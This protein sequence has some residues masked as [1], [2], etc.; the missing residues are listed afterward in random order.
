M[1]GAQCTH[2]LAC[3]MNKAHERSHHR[4]TG[5]FPAFPAQW[6][7]GLFR[8]LPGEIGLVCHRYLAPF[9]RRLDTGV[10]ASEPHDFAVRVSTIRHVRCSRPPHPAPRW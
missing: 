1:P 7:Y 4:F 10:E 9:G 2:S 5:L 8:A 6:F 3:E